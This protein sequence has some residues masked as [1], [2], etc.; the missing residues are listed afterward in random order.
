MKEFI[1]YVVNGGKFY[2]IIKLVV[3]DGIEIEYNVK[4]YKYVQKYVIVLNYVLK[5]SF[6]GVFIICKIG[7]MVKNE[8]GELVEEVVDLKVFDII[9]GVILKLFVNSV[10][11]KLI[12][13]KILKILNLFMGFK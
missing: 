5:V 10:I 4:V 12:M 8:K 13:E 2:F 1:F 11:F 9:I 7:R 6:L 3:F